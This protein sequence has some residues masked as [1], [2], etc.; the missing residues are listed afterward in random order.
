MKSKV[1]ILGNSGF[2]GSSLE[3]DLM[4]GGG[5]QVEGL[6]SSDLDLSAKESTEKLAKVLNRETILF[7][8]TRSRNAQN[9]VDAYHHNILIDQNIARC[10]EKN[11]VKKC[12]YLSS[13]SVY[14][15][16]S[17]N[18][19]ITENTPVDPSTLYGLTNFAGEKSITGY[20]SK[21]RVSIAGLEVLQGL[22]TWKPGYNFL[23]AGPIHNFNHKG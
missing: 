6:N 21:S 8:F 1:V 22:W 14:G 7:V 13:I 3:K 12:L 4:E 9:K 20:R 11:P 17:T 2:I 23:W 15:E 16:V 10:L 19:E 18:D 5:I